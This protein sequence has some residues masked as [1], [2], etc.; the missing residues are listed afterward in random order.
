M[1]WHVIQQSGDTKAYLKKK[2]WK[3]VR[4]GTISSDY[5]STGHFHVYTLPEE[6]LRSFKRNSANRVTRGLLFFVH[7]K[8]KH[9]VNRARRHKTQNLLLAVRKELISREVFS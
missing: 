7:L 4:Q 2:K 6:F 1:G 5:R 8:Y 9:F 3:D